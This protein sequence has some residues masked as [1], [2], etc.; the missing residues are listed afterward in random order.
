MQKTIGLLRAKAEMVFIIAQRIQVPNNEV[1][2]C[3][4]IIIMVQVLGKYMIVRY[5]DPLGK[6]L[7]GEFFHFTYLPSPADSRVGHVP[8]F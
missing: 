4:V 5:L 3:G 2:G 7:L 1:L 8:F 6:S